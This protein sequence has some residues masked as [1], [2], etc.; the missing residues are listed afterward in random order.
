MWSPTMIC[1]VRRLHAVGLAI[2]GTMVLGL[3]LAAPG[4]GS[5]SPDSVL[6]AKGL[7]RIGSTYVLKEEEGLGGRVRRFEELVDGWKKDRKRLEEELASL[8]RMRR[9]YGQLSD[10][11]GPADRF[12]GPGPPPG[13]LMP[14]P[15][16][17]PGPPGDGPPPDDRPDF[18][19]R[20]RDGPPGPPRGGTDPRRMDRPRAELEARMTLAQFHADDLSSR[21][22]ARMRE[23]RLRR[24]QALDVHRRIMSG[25]AEL[26]ADATVRQALEAINRA[27]SAPVSLGPS[28]DLGETLR[29]IDA[30]L[31]G[32]ANPAPEPASR[33]ELHGANRLRGLVG[34]A[35]LLLHEVAVSAGRLATIERERN[36]RRKLLA[37]Q[38]LKDRKLADSIQKAGTDR[39][40]AEKASAEI[41]NAKTRTDH[42]RAEQEQSRIASRDVLDQM[43]AEQDQFLQVVA[44]ARELIGVMVKQQDGSNVGAATPRSNPAPASSRGPSQD[45]SIQPYARRLNELEKQ[46]RSENVAVDVD[47]GLIWVDAT[48]DGSH[49]LKMI[50]EPKVEG[51]RLAAVTATQAGVRPIDGE[52]AVE[53]ETPDGR[54]LP[55]RRAR[56]DSVQIGTCILRD[57]ECLVLSPESGVSPPLIG[58]GFLKRFSTRIDPNAGTMTLTQLTVKP[59]LRGGEPHR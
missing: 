4:E 37:D 7:Q 58:G 25:Y 20:D 14:P 2:G 15:G 13:G 19:P 55:A 49:R 18:G 56:L 43:V 46:I 21:L 52:P 59:I 48:I 3:C 23:L 17:G 27:S 11:R 28:R 51:L 6:K 45:P 54:M 39:A 57:V 53:V 50:V 47:R 32:T 24:D 35:D 10:P 29:R 12:D 1:P 33:L 5:R 30:P 42:L 9:R 8:G 31:A 41:R 34:A 26:A 38:R 22:E 16:M 44:A 40:Q 36:S